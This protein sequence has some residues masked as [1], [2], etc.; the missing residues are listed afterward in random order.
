MKFKINFF[1][2]T[3]SARHDA[4]DLED[5]LWQFGKVESHN[6][7]NLY[8]FTLHTDVDEDFIKTAVN[9]TQFEGEITINKVEPEDEEC[10]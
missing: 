7:G 8:Q 1:S 4:R 3:E 6:S 5:I 2:N 9:T 10:S